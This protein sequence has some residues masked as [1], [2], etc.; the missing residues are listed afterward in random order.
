LMFDERIDVSSYT[1][2]Y[3]RVVVGGFTYV[4]R[5]WGAPS[6]LGGWSN[7]VFDLSK[8]VST[9]SGAPVHPVGVLSSIS[10]TG[11]STGAG[12]SAELQ[13]KNVMVSSLSMPAVDSSKITY[14]MS[15]LGAQKIVVDGQLSGDNHFDDMKLLS[16]HVSGN[17]SIK[18][19]SPEAK[20]ASTG[21]GRFATFNLGTE[22]NVTIDLTDESV[23]KFDA[24]VNGSSTTITVYGGQIVARLSSPSADYLVSVSGAQVAAYNYSRFE[25]AFIS[26]PFS[27]YNPGLPLE[28]NGQINFKVSAMDS[29]FALISKLN[30]NGNYR[31]LT[32]SQAAMSEWNIPWVTVMTSP[33]QILLLSAIIIFSVLKVR[34][35]KMSARKKV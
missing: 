10:W 24:I 32:Q 22:C 34:L 35:H 29:G 7:N 25:R 31:V 6:S 1:L 18:L 9:Q 33:L 2:G 21:N 11:F 28:V 26:W 13:I 5:D 16:M 23:L 20:F 8:A 12:G 17:S 4:V 15:I 30:V 19:V 27:I 3:L 14:S